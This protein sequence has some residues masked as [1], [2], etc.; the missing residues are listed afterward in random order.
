MNKD[1]KSS[2]VKQSLRVFRDKQGLYRVDGR[3]GNYSSRFN[4]NYPLLL[5]SDGQFTNLIIFEAHNIVKHMGV[6]STLNETRQTFWIC[7]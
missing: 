6:A 4:R 5:R 2:K 1:A 3:F 7:K